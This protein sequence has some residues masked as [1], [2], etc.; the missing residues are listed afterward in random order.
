MPAASLAGMNS[1]SLYKIWWPM[2]SGQAWHFCFPIVWCDVTECF[3]FSV[4]KW[5]QIVLSLRCV[6]G[7]SPVAVWILLYNHANPRVWKYNLV[8][9]LLGQ[10]VVKSVLLS[11]SRVGKTPPYS[12]IPTTLPHCQFV[13]LQYPSPDIHAA[14]TAINPKPAFINKLRGFLQ[15][16]FGKCCFFLVDPMYLALFFLLRSG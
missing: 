1:T 13:T 10:V 4:F 7:H 14:F 6:W 2:V 15:S 11:K 9:F 12:N 16:S 5:P 3:A 8:V